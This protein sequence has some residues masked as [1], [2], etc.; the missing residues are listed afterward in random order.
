MLKW[1]QRALQTARKQESTGGDTSIVAI[2]MSAESG[3]PAQRQSAT[4]ADQ[5]T[6][7][8]QAQKL[9]RAAVPVIRISG[10]GGRH[11]K[12]NVEKGARVGP[13]LQGSYDILNDAA[14]RRKG[15][16]L[17]LVS[18]DDAVLRYVGISRNGLKHR[19]RTSPAYDALTMER[20]EKNQLFHSQCWKH[21][22]RESNASPGV[23]FEVRCLAAEEIIRLAGSLG[24]QVQA[25]VQAFGEDH[26]SI[27]AS[28]E[29]W[30]CN[31]SA[32]DLLTW[33]V[34]MTSR[35]PT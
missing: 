25:L 22:E 21:I 12:R 26:E 14:W 31:H 4:T 2:A 33:N 11:W 15:A 7:H 6:A 13:W 35:R 30:L 32:P 28:I 1:I 9:F 27:V 18:G 24:T 23:A 29:R 3:Q 10:V 17:Y 20:L 34:A 19:W 5:S 8:A 16:C